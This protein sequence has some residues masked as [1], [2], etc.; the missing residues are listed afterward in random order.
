MNAMLQREAQQCARRV[1]QRQVA[2]YL[3]NHAATYSAAKTY[4]RNDEGQDQYK[5]AQTHCEAKVGIYSHANV[6]IK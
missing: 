4:F 6:S 3:H 5:A 2:Q 1:K